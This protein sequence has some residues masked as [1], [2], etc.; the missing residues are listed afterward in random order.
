MKFMLLFIES[1]QLPVFFFWP[2]SN[3]VAFAPY[4]LFFVSEIEFF[5]VKNRILGLKF[6]GL[7]ATQRFLML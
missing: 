4:G 3:A 5:S 6:N 1:W 2:G 7:V